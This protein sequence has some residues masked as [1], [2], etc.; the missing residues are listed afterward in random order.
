MQHC[1]ERIRH[2]IFSIMLLQLLFST[3]L[4]F[5][6]VIPSHQR[7]YYYS[8]TQQQQQQQKAHV[9]TNDNDQDSTTQ[10]SSSSS[11]T[12][13][14][15]SMTFCNLD[16]DK[17]PQLLCDFLMEIGACSTSIVDANAETTPLE[18]AIF[19]EQPAI[20]TWEDVAV[21][22][23][24]WNQ[25]NVTALFPA[26]VDLHHV[27]TMVQETFENI[28]IDESSLSNNND[29]NVVPNRDWVLHVQQSWKP[30]MISGLV[31][32][33]PWHSQQDVQEVIQQQQNNNVKVLAEL[34]LEGGIAFG[35]GEHPTTQ[36]CVMW[37]IQTLKNDKS[38]TNI[39][40]YGT[41][42]G[43]LGL[44][45]C[46]IT[47]NQCK[48]VGVDIDI[49]AVQI[50]NAN[51]VTN[52]LSFRAHLPPLLEETTTT[53]DSESKSILM[54]AYQSSNSDTLMLLPN[55][56]TTLYDACVANILAVPLVTLA[57][58]LASMIKPCGYLALS[59]ILESQA[60]IVIEAYSEF[61]DNVKV[62]NE[63]GGWILITGK[64]QA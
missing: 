33:F 16:K 64:R 1:H 18:E 39:L 42:S 5:V 24:V 17:Q 50:A 38:I 4:A 59:G 56:N 52:G 34:Q 44:A 63:K 20:S 32:R 30:I 61:F 43:I 27:A 8:T 37:I 55:D 14:L 31:L 19:Q 7:P 35:T 10:A 25:C 23:N 47:N 15:R 29:N 40:D 57:P 41:G 48:A 3:S 36:L 26:S 53:Q 45:A 22:Q 9:S 2:A 62:E 49:D 54:K 6:V 11:S 28:P 60:D 58:T 12:T 13:L 21:G 46:A 51:A